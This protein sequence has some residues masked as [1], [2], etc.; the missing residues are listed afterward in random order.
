[1]PSGAK[2]SS[3]NAR[4]CHTPGPRGRSPGSGPNLW[5][6]VGRV[7]GGAEGFKFSA[8]LSG[9]GGEWSYEALNAFLTK[10]KD[11]ASGNKMTFPGLKKAGDRAAVIVYLR[12]LSDSPSPLP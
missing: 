3:T 1:M 12:S 9:L 7:K 5:D 6:V 4:A 10:P 11:F 2:R 8:S